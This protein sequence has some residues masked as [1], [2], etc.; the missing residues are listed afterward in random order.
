MELLPNGFTLELCP[1]AFPLST[2]S[3]VLADFVRLRRSA[4]VLDL[5]S[6]CGTLGLLLC[7]SDP[8]CTVTGLELDENAHAQALKNIRANALEPRLISI[9]ADLRA[10]PEEIRRQSFDCCVSNPPYFTGGAPSRKTPL[11][12]QDAACSLPELFAAADYAL[13]YG[14]DFFLIH[15]PEKLAS[16]C[17]EA[18]RA[19]LEPKVLRLVRHDPGAVPSLIALQCRKGGK[20][21]LR[22][23]EITLFHADGSPTEDYRRIYLRCT[24]R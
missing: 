3:M 4:R 22:L 10:M 24:H 6:G 8:G 18:G 19:G 12:R 14:G 23:E 7:A 20:P 17:M 21:G 9:C 2:D 11:A 1:G 16:I 15:K 13:R 5:G